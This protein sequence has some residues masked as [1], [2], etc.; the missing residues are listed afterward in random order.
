MHVMYMY[1]SFG[2]ENAVLN[3]QTMDL[4]LGNSRW[5]FSTSNAKFDQNIQQYKIL[6]YLVEIIDHTRQILL[7]K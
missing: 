2:G 7:S 1:A 5:H 3:N 6:S 4:M